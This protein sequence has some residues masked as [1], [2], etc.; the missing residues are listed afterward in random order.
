MKTF[1][2]TEEN[3]Q[4]V[5]FVYLCIST[6]HGDD[7]QL[8]AFVVLLICDPLQ[9]QSIVHASVI[10]A[11]LKGVK[12]ADYSTGEDDIMVDILAGSEQ[13]WQLVSGKV[14]QGEDGPT[15]IQTRLGWVLSG[16]TNGAVQQPCDNACPQDGYKTC[17]HFK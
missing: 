3:T 9:S 4:S 2:S 17:G 12:L 15:A 11:H 5:D 7:V 13:Y 16:P 1:G 8:S 14:L 6:E 10:H